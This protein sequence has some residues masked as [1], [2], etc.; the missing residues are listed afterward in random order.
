MILNDLMCYFNEII[1]AANI[2]KKRLIR[3]TSLNTYNL[4]FD[5]TLFTVFPFPVRYNRYFKSLIVKKYWLFD[6][7]SLCKLLQ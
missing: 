4:I 5:I 1:S 3:W 2:N 6:Q 7:T